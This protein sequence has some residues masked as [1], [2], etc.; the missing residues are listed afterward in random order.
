MIKVSPF[1]LTEFINEYQRDMRLS[2]RASYTLND[3]LYV[4]LDGMAEGLID[5]FVIRYEKLDDF[6]SYINVL[7]DEVT[8]LHSM[9]ILI[10]ALALVDE[11]CHG[12]VT[13]DSKITESRKIKEIFRK[14]K[15]NLYNEELKRY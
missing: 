13:L 7:R 6:I 1:T 10:L 14:A 3:P 15:K 2:K 12:L 9:D 5:V 11:E 8:W 4:L